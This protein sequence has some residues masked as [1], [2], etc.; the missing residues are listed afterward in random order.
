[1]H[2]SSADPVFMVIFQGRPAKMAHGTL[3]KESSVDSENQPIHNVNPVTANIPLTFPTVREVKAMPQTDEPGLRAKVSFMTTIKTRDEELLVRSVYPSLRDCE[4]VSVVE[5]GQVGAP[6]WLVRASEAKCIKDSHAAGR[7]VH[8]LPDHSVP[9]LKYRSI[10]ASYTNVETINPRSFLS[11]EELRS[12]RKAFPG[13]TGTQVPLTGW[14]LIMFAEKK[15]METCWGKGT[16]DEI[17]GLRVGY[18]LASFQGTAE[19]IESKPDTFTQ[20]AAIGLRLRLPGGLEAI[21]TVSHA[22]VRLADPRMSDRRKR[23]MEHI[24]RAKDYL[25]KMRPQSSQA[26]MAG[27]VRS[28]LLADS[29][30]GKKVWLGG[31]NTCVCALLSGCPDEKLKQD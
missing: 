31:T 15:A 27:I 26:P 5:D 2:V 29:P 3:L 6:L 30:L 25:K 14:L 4:H 11:P 16:P 8:V 1:M 10:P 22:F 17:G 28:N 13:S 24:L 9:P 12:I 7:E 18:T 21:T 23:F 19:T 20:Q